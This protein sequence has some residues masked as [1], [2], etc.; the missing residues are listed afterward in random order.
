VNAALLADAAAAHLSAWRAH[1]QGSRSARLVVVAHSMGGLVAR[2]FTGVLGGAG[3]T[4]CTVTLGT[5]FFGAAK[6]AYTLSTGRGTP[7]P[8]PRARLRRLLRGMPG[9]YALLPAYRCVDEGRTSR[10]LTPS[11][12]GGLGGDAELAEESMRTQAVLRTDD[13]RGLRALV[14]VEQ[15]TMQS[16][17]LRDGVAEGREYTCLNGDG[18]VLRREDR[19]GDGT[20]YR[21]SAAP[22]GAEPVYLP[23]THTAIAKTREAVAHVRAVLTETAM[24]PPLGEAAI[25]MALPDVVAVAKPFEIGVNT[26]G[27][28]PATVSCRVVDASSGAQVARPVLGLRDG[29]LSAVAALPEPGMYRVELDGGG[30]SPV[31]DL[32]LA[33]PNAD[34]NQALE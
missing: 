31:S 15:P 29:R 27:P 17:L 30:G 33:V 7:L 22:G 21:E 5:P 3:E 10:M 9:L 20:V 13:A 4:R 6:A 23:Q 14:G 19:R 26:S 18:G 28:D 34:L 24:G 2:W 16:L 32:V 1:P 8:L 12:V 11:D 25:G